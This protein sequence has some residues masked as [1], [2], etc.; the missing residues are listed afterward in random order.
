MTLKSDITI[1]FLQLHVLLE[2]KFEFKI[3]HLYSDNGGEY[4]S[5]KPYLNKHD[6]SHLTTPPHTP[7]HNG[8]S[9]RRH[10]QIV[11]TGM[12]LLTQANLPQKFWC[13]S[14]QTIVY[15]INRLPTPIL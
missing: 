13:L 1:I 8:I 5:L 12:T 11:E 4:I 9:E 14:F 7:Q 6:I 3:T 10:R 2:K 15:L